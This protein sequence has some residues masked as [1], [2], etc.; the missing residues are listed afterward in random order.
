MTGLVA[1]IG[2]M[3]G[4]EKAIDKLIDQGAKAIDVLYYSN[5]EKAVDAAKDVSEVRSMI[6]EWMKNTEGQN[7]ARRFISIVVTG[8]WTASHF[9]AVSLSAVSVWTGHPELWMQSSKTVGEFA[10]KTTGAMM[11]VLGFY[12]AAPHLGAIVTG[13]IER[14]GG[15]K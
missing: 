4:T 6:V 11:L 14:F 5:E 1:W 13:A 10:E 12:F 8:T 2:K 3:F 9:V 15:K 7:L